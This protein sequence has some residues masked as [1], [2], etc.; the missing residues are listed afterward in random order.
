MGVMLGD[1]DP[2]AVLAGVEW[3]DEVV[4]ILTG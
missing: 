4:D 3:V 1:E 2:E